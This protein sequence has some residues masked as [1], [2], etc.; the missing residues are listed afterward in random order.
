MPM[1]FARLD[2]TIIDVYQAATQMTDESG[3]SYPFTVDTLLDRALGAEGYYGAYMVNAHTDFVASP[4]SDAVVNS[5]Q[6]RGRADRLQPPDADLARRPQRIVV[7][8]AQLGRQR[9]QLHGRQD[10]AANGLQAMLP[11]RSADGALA[12]LTRGGSPVSFTVEHD[13]GRRLRLF[14]RRHGGTTSPPT[15]PTR[16]APT[17]LVDDR[18]LPAP[19]A[20]ADHSRA[21]RPSASR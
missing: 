19:P 12:S 14:R 1:R 18:P 4:E 15:A 7:R 6:A 3:Q 5:A 8:L 2:G 17:V 20:S 11:A 16:R 9:T 21:P 13:Q 10:P